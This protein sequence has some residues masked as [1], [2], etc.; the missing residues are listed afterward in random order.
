MAGADMKG[1]THF[2]SGVA[3]ATFSSQA[4]QM[5]Q[6]DQSLIIVLGGIFGILPDTLDFKVARFFDNEDHIISPKPKDTNLQ[7]IA[8]VLA[9]AI[10]QAHDEGKMIKVKLNTIKLGADM[11]RQYLINFQEDEVIVRLGPVVNTGKVQL[12]TFDFENAPEARAKVRS[13]VLHTYDHDTYVDIFSGPTFGFKKRKDDLIEAEFLPW[14]RSWSHSLVLGVIFGII[15][16]L[17]YGLLTSYDGHWDVARLYG[18]VICGGFC[19]HILEDQL[20][21]MGSNLYWPFTKERAIG[22]KWMRSGDAW[23]N[24]ITVW[25]AVITIIFNINRFSNE[26]AFQ[27][28]LV[29]YLGYAFFMPLTFILL[30]GFFTTK[31]LR[32]AVINEDEEKFKEVFVENEEENA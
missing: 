29:E 11:W 13:R 18:L 31:L 23:P 12:G 3:L 16:F 22:L 30:I 28:S 4:V 17:I 2:I 8:D 6:N 14:H 10:D 9:K 1:L 24:F 25:I 32:P 21:F 7:E 27:A 19:I 15:G 5:A 26:P 20:G